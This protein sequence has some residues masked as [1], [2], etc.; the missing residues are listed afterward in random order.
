MTLILAAVSRSRAVLAADRRIAWGPTGGPYQHA[1]ADKL[2]SVRGCAV[3]SFGS[4]PPNTDVPQLIRALDSSCTVEATCLASTLHARVSSLPDP[5]DFG[6]L[7]L[8]MSAGQASL[9]E[10]QSKGGVTAHELTPGALLSRGVAVPLPQLS[11]PEEEVALRERLLRV[12]RQAAQQTDSVG[13]PYEFAFLSPDA[14]ISISR[15]DA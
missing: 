9:C 5:G 8:G 12:F 15:S 10:I 14:A 2:F 3:A 4:S 6:M 13:P 7:V 1:E 11:L